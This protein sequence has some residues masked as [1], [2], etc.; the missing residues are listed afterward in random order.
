MTVFELGT[1]T[2]GAVGEYR[3]CW[4]PVPGVAQLTSGHYAA[5]SGAVDAFPIEVP[6]PLARHPHTRH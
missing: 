1:P 6:R 2:K 5:A 3:L 4:G